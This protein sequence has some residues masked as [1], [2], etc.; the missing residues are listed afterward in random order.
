L[1]Q[2]IGKD[3]KLLTA[4]TLVTMSL[5]DKKHIEPVD[6]QL[7]KTQIDHILHQQLWHKQMNQLIGRDNKL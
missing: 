4:Q 2:L 7:H 1:S 5:V 6:Q 3:N